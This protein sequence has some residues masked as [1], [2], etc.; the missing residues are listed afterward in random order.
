MPDFHYQDPF[1]IG[2]DSTKYRK[3]EG[4]EQ[5]VSIGKFDGK[6]VLKVE[7]EALTVLANQAM[8]DIS[9]MLR[10][11]HNEQV[12]KILSDPEASQ[13]DRGVAM[14]FLRNAEISANF[15]LPICQDTGTEPSSPKKVRMSGPESTT[16]SNC[17][18]GFSIPTLKKTSA[19][20]RP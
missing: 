1:P 19:T 2:K 13:N 14:A 7:P 17:H 15:E 18:K 4:S 8:R 6:D 16:L 20:A 10:P 5:Y 12:A 11:E 9:F 3:V